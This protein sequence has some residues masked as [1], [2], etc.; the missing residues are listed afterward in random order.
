MFN[1]R[2]RI[3]VGTVFRVRVRFYLLM[4]W[5]VMDRHFSVICTHFFLL[6]CAIRIKK[7]L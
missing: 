2:V 6:K 7:K 5:R 1:L 4:H 3:R